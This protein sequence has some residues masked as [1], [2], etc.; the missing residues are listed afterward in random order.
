MGYPNLNLITMSY[1]HYTPAP[2]AALNNHSS[3]KTKLIKDPNSQYTNEIYFILK[4]K[5]DLSSE[6]IP[7]CAGIAPLAFPV[8]SHCR[9]THSDYRFLQYFCFSTPVSVLK[10]QG[11][12]SNIFKLVYKQSS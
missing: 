12:S 3:D 1:S 9:D 5:I 4:I 8:S 7:A 6:T 2:W 10:P 11:Q